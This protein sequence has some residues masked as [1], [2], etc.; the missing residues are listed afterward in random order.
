M[1]LAISCFLTFFTS[2]HEKP[3]FCGET[4]LWEDFRCYIK[5][6]TYFITIFPSCPWLWYQFYN[7]VYSTR[8]VTSFSK[9]AL[10]MCIDFYVLSYSLSHLLCIGGKSRSNRRSTSWAALAV[11]RNVSSLLLTKRYWRKFTY[12]SASLSCVYGKKIPNHSWTLQE[13]VGVLLHY[14][15]VYG[16]CALEGVNICKSLISPHSL[17]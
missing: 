12:A 17:A 13:L 4:I 15:I 3:H 7:N 16:S 11:C 8:A 2:F 6:I 1:V 10:S 5:Y 9:S 14:H